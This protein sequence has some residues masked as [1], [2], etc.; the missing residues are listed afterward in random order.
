MTA[1]A[2][3]DATC[4][5]IALVE[6]LDQAAEIPGLIARR[7]YSP[8]GDEVEK[9]LVGPEIWCVEKST[10]RERIARDTVCQEVQIYLSFLKRLT[11]H[12]ETGD[13]LA[14]AE[15]DELRG[16]V[17]DV[18]A[19]LLPPEGE[20]FQVSIDGYVYELT[21]IGDASGREL[22]DAPYDYLRIRNKRLWVSTLT[23]VFS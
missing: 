8:G 15:A 3:S 9:S 10:R 14:L 17:D 13:S 1:P 7:G 22:A 23:L 19:S 4:I 20:P 16:F 6:H 2:L 11:Q 18:A 21:S 5:L 12:S